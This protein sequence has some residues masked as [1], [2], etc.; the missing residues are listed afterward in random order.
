[1]LETDDSRLKAT[2]A[3]IHRL[4]YVAGNDEFLCDRC[5]SLICNA[6]ADSRNQIFRFT[7][8]EMADGYFEELFTSIS[9]M[10]ERRAAVIQ[11]FQIT[12]MGAAA[13]DL[14]TSLLIDIPEDLTI[15]LRQFDEDKRFT[16]PKK[17]LEFVSSVQDSVFCAVHAKTGR[18][19]ERYINALA[20]QH[21]CTI[22][23]SAVQRLAELHGENLQ[24]MDTEIAKLAALAGYGEIGVWHID[25]LSTRTAEAYVFN[26]ISAM[27]KG[28]TSQALKILSD[29]MDDLNEPLQITSLI[30]TAF[31][32]LYRTRL[33]RDSG[34]NREWLCDNF[35]YASNDRRLAIAMSNCSRFSVEKL[36]GIIELLV[37]LDKR[38]KSS[39]IDK[40]YI[41]EQSVVEI[42]M[43]VR[44]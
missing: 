15:V 43:A 40:R 14:L 2:I 13:K 8:K 18:E 6:A 11:D 38:L 31:L 25:Q 19:L 5:V 9:L 28:N 42:T 35:G 36:E 26:M 20:R 7:M 21:N 29:M 32:N 12:T 39:A 3:T 37:L 27:E 41:L 4:Y 17:A 23:D 16:A 30:T 10:P 22:E 1:M 33:A 34:R 44:S 24:L